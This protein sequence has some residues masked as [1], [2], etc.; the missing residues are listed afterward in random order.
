MPFASVD[1]STRL[2]YRLEGRP[3]LPVLILSHSL[4]C[5]HGMWDLQMPALLEHFRVLRYDTRGHGA[6]DVTPGEAY[7]VEQLARDAVALADALGIATFDFCGLSLGGMTG[8]RI[9]A[10]TSGRL[11]RLVL[12]NTSAK[13]PDVG[14]MEARRKTVLAEGMAAVADAVMDRFLRKST[15]ESG[16][17]HAA[18]LRTVLLA[19]DLVG[20][21]ACCGAVRDLDNREILGAIQN[22]TLIISSEIDLSTPWKG[23][24]DLLAELIPHAEVL[25]LE[26][27]H[28]SNIEAPREF[29]E[30][31]IRFLVK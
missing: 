1:R 6:S 9:A 10:G 26:T 21:A 13:F 29:A 2:Y 27:A 11:R 28:L 24:G 15:Q 16:N 30:A 20:Y 31:V 14:P 4:G 8:M 23:H 7:S 18:T 5:D 3:E 17:P 19:T 12:A 25:M 22:P